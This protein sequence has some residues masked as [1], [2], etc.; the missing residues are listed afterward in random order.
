VRDGT[1]SAVTGLVTDNLSALFDNF[2]MFRLGR[3][4]F[5]RDPNAGA[6]ANFIRI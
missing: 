4:G 5:G 1:V 3:Y 6:N 2:F